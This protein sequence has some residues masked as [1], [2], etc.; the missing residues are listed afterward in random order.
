MATRL[1]WADNQGTNDYSVALGSNLTPGSILVLSVA[2]RQ[3][4][5]TAPTITD[6]QSLT[7]T[8]RASQGPLFAG[9]FDGRHWIFTAP[10]P[11][12]SGSCTVSINYTPASGGHSGAYVVEV[13]AGSYESVVF[14]DDGGSGNSTASVGDDALYLGFAHDV[15]DATM[16][17]TSPT[18][19]DSSGAAGFHRIFGEAALDTGQ[20]DSTDVT[21]GSGFKFTAGVVIANAGASPVTVAG[22]IGAVQI[23]GIAGVLPIP[24]E[25][26]GAIGVLTVVGIAATIDN[27]SPDPATDPFTYSNGAL[28]TVSSGLWESVDGNMN[29]ASNV[30][31]NPANGID[32]AH[33][34]VDPFDT[35]HYSEADCNVSTSTGT[36]ESMAVL[37]RVDVAAQSYYALSVASNGEIQIY[38]REGESFTS[39]QNEAAPSESGRL[40]LESQGSDHRAYFNGTLIHSWSD[41]TLTGDQVGVGGFRNSAS[42]GTLDNWEGGSFA[43]ATVAGAIGTVTVVGIP[44]NAAAVGGS[45]TASGAIGVVQAV[46]IA[47]TLSYAVSG[48][49]AVGVVQMVGIAGIGFTDSPWPTTVSGRKILDQFGNVWLCKAMSWWTAAQLATDA[50][51]VSAIEQLHDL[52]FNAITVGPCGFQFNSSGWPDNYENEAGEEFF[53]GSPLTSSFGPAWDS[54]DLVMD[55][56]RDYG[57]TVLFSIYWGYPDVFGSQGIGDELAGITNAQAR[58]YGENVA[59]RYGDYPNLMWHMGAD[60]TWTFG[61]TEA[62]RIDNVF[63][64]LVETES[65][66]HLIT[67]EPDAS[68]DS[69]TTAWDLYISDTDPGV[70]VSG[71]GW[72]IPDVNSFYS[73]TAQNSVEAFDATYNESGATNIP[74]WD[75][76]PAYLQ[77]SHY[78][79]DLQEHR[80]RTWAVM[81]RDSFGINFGIEQFCSCGHPTAHVATS[82]EDWLDLLVDLAGVTH[83]SICWTLIDQ[84]LHDD[85]WAPTTDGTF[86]TTGTGS[87]DTKAAVGK[88]DTA[89]IAYFPNSR[90][91]AIDTT[92][93]AGTEFVRLRWYDPTDGS[94]TV[95]TQG[96]AQ[97]S[98]RSVTHPGNGSNAAGGNDWVLVVDDSQVIN[99]T[100][101]IGTVQIVGIAGTTAVGVVGPGSLAALQIVGIAGTADLDALEAA[102]AVGAIHVVGIAGTAAVSAV[103]EGAIGVISVVG[104]AGSVA[105]QANTIA[106]AIGQLTVVGVAGN[107][108]LGSLEAAGAIGTLTVASV[109][110]TVA[111]GAIEAAGA[112]GTVTV[113]GIAGS[114]A[115]NETIATGAI[116]TLSA[117]G[118]GGTVAT[119]SITATGAIGVAVIVGIAGSVVAPVNIQGAIGL[120]Y[121][122][123]LAGGKSGA[124]FLN[125][126]NKARITRDSRVIITRDRHEYGIVTP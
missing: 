79:G 81:L 4:G 2:A 84:Y 109:A 85:T 3:S 50:E 55:T 1:Q 57:I 126:A 90:T 38:M 98:G 37:T 112:I 103:A 108:A 48:V 15:S 88:S 27:G 96:E 17:M 29:V 23:V 100:G 58:T 106:G 28:P 66:H 64:G 92:V 107:A 24:E 94:F 124:D 74:C 125:W 21:S 89:A 30:L 59:A 104:I 25:V 75:C 39:I 86:V 80:E 76:E 99:V 91:I 71:Y 60:K 83:A 45:V 40:R 117:V 105:G 31:V 20:T 121:C 67:C 116:G 123:G 73:N 114:I 46:G 68:S 49:G 102:G 97:Q 113:V 119:D 43:E 12:A 56:A 70:G 65:T 5:G 16:S 11:S 14:D 61:S 62:A 35:D 36:F 54:M 87:G 26:A 93:L 101:A 78:G 34:W 9:L 72:F 19:V 51:I 18:S 52:G 41:S 77:S 115:G 10:N 13:G 32:Y 118:I 47:G 6:T 33:A 53:T 120:L 122:V 111:T 63:R 110:G 8:E 69:S 22:A 82:D 42:G 44:G 7:W 95:I